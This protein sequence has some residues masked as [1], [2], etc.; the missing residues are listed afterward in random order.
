MWE[1]H[2]S[3]KSGIVHAI[4]LPACVTGCGK[5]IVEFP[6]LVRLALTCKGCKAF[7]FKW[8]KDDPDLNETLFYMDDPNKGMTEVQ[9]ENCRVDLGDDWNKQQQ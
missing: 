3:K 7:A 5:T 4:S 6:N 1:R 9:R 8:S 2:L